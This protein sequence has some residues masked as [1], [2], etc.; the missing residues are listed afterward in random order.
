MNTADIL[1]TFILTTSSSD[2][3]KRLSPSSEIFSGGRNCQFQNEHG[4]G[5]V[6]CSPIFLRMNSIAKCYLYVLF[7]GPQFYTLHFSSIDKS[8]SGLPVPPSFKRSLFNFSFAVLPNASHPDDSSFSMEYMGHYFW[9]QRPFCRSQPKKIFAKFKRAL[10]SPGKMAA[11][12]LITIQR[13]ISWHRVLA[14][15][16]NPPSHCLQR[17]VGFFGSTPLKWNLIRLLPLP[18]DP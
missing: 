5:S 11:N 9:L 14:G 10:R 4:G 1:L 18:A 13:V 16:K 15:D 8:L 6:S 2:P 17:R 12:T 3:W 7:W